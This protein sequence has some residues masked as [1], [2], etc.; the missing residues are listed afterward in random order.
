MRYLAQRK[1]ALAEKLGSRAMRADAME[2]ITC[3]WLSLVAVIGLVAQAV[4]GAWWVDPVG[5]LAIVWFLVKEGREAW[6][7]EECGCG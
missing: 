7:G 6:A 4:L 5:S 2:S 3:G 1:I